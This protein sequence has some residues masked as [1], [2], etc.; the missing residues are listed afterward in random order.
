MRTI[1][2][3]KNEKIEE[4]EKFTKTSIE[5]VIKLATKY[6]ITKVKIRKN[7][8][9]LIKPD[10]QGEPCC[11]SVNLR[12]R[13]ISENN[14][15]YYCIGDLNEDGWVNKFLDNFY[16]WLEEIKNEEDEKMKKFVAEYYIEG[17]IEKMGFFNAKNEEEVKNY[18]I[19]KYGENVKIIQITELKGVGVQ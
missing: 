1:N 6:K 18:L 8:Y 5:E 19:K 16:E 7:G 13:D 2:E 15:F 9:I 11:G 10:C 4:F 3:N 14:N 17:G 12:I